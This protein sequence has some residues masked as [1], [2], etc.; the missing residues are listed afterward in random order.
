MVYQSVV[1][2][3]RSKQS[4]PITGFEHGAFIVVF[5][6]PNH[7]AIDDHIF[8]NVKLIQYKIEHFSLETLQMGEIGNIFLQKIS[9]T[10]HLSEFKSP[11]RQ[12][13]P[14]ESNQDTPVPNQ[15]IQT[16]TNSGFSYFL[17]RVR[18]ILSCGYYVDCF[19]IDRKKNG[20][21][22]ITQKSSNRFFV[23][24]VCIQTL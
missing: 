10:Y 19:L 1:V 15:D 16:S 3:K 2:A 5:R 14:P 11:V 13:D 22:Y 7:Y 23:F 6:Y 12:E 18:Y 21:I 4:Q 20:Y 9:D 8:P 17:K 24:L